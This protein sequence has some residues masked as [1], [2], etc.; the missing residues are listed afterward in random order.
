MIFGCSSAPTQLPRL[1]EAAGKLG[2]K[3]KARTDRHGGV[4]RAE[5]AD[6]FGNDPPV[7]TASLNEAG[8]KAICLLPEPDEH[9]SGIES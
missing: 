2:P 8:L 3:R 9:C 7:D 4:N 5:R 6:V 1:R